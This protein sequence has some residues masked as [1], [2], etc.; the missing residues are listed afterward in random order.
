MLTERQLLIFKAIIDDFIASAQP[1]GSRT[2]SEKEHI[3]VS[4]ATIRNVMAE[5][6]EMGYLEK[7]HTSS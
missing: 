3:T 5:L 7:T 2:I 4:A 6:E 1:V